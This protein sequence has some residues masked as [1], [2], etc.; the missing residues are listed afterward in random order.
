MSIEH[1]LTVDDFPKWALSALINGDYSSL[2]CDDTIT[3]DKFLDYFAKVTHWDVDMESLEDGNFKRY[4]VFGLATDC[5]TVK[6]YAAHGV[7]V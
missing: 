1:V 7:T 3:L 5:C 6:G 4:P 2:N